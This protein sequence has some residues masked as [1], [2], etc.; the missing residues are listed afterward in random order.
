MYN[1]L[2]NP[3]IKDY[4]FFEMQCKNKYNRRLIDGTITGCGNCVGYCQYEGHKGFLNESQRKQ[5]NCIGKNC[6]YYTEKSKPKRQKE[7][8]LPLEILNSAQKEASEIEGV[9]LLRADIKNNIC[10]IEYI[11]ITNVFLLKGISELLKSKFGIQI[12]FKKLN[13]DFDRIV[14]IM[15]TS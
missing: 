6:F 15:F 8:N 4:V 12:K 13:Y 7:S 1:Q 10:E 14:D 3:E 9:K 5:H 2:L 11:T